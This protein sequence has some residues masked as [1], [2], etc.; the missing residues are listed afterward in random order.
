MKLHKKGKCF[1]KGNPG[2]AFFKVKFLNMYENCIKFSLEEGRQM[3]KDV[4]E[5]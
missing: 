1:Q 3:E 4:V 5:L 2:C